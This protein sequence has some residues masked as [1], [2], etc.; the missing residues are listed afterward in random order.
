[1]DKLEQ[2]WKKLVEQNN[3]VTSNMFNT[4]ARS[5]AFA[6]YRKR[7]AEFL[8]RDKERVED[9]DRLLED[10]RRHTQLGDELRATEQNLVELNGMRAKELEEVRHRNAMLEEQLEVDVRRLRK[11]IERL[12]QDK[13]K[14]KATI[15][16][17]KKIIGALKRDSTNLGKMQGVVHTELEGI[18]KEVRNLED[19][20]AK[21]EP[22]QDEVIKLSKEF[23]R[24]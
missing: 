2:S 20:V 13:E 3:Q 5:S 9:I 21:A 14:Q 15:A 8:R 12:K 10:N 1:M 4:L 24:L 11:G 16:S 19:M 6:A 17:Q 22:E 18:R 7:I 23:E